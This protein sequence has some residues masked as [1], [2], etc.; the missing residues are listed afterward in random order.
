MASSLLLLTSDWSSNIITPESCFLT[1]CPDQIYL[2][3]A[4]HRAMWRS[5]ISSKSSFLFVWLFL[6]LSLIWLWGWQCLFYSTFYLPYLA[7]CK[8]FKTNCW[9]NK[10][11]EFL[12]LIYFVP[13]LK[14]SFNRWDEG[15]SLGW[16]WDERQIGHI[17]NLIIHQCGCI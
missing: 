9:V 5:Q 14:I 7:H 3:L 8:Y 13:W 1:P 6:F 11:N 4:F 16:A 10:L 17:S 2:L 15:F 12:T